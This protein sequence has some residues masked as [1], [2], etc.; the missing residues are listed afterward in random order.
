MGVTNNEIGKL[1]KEEKMAGVKEMEKKGREG[2]KR[3]KEMK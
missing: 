2:K 3:E 1:K